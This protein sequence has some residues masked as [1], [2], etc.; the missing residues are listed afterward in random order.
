MIKGIIRIQKETKNSVP[1]VRE[2]NIP[3]EQMPLVD[4]I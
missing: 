4:E 3:T 2:R 1:L